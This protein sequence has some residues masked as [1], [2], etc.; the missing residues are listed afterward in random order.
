VTQVPGDKYH[1]FHWEAIHLISMVWRDDEIGGLGG[2]ME[3]DPVLVLYV[4]VHASRE[5]R[6]LFI[7]SEHFDVYATHWHPLLGLCTCPCSVK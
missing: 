5:T 6:K 4:R 7:E 3:R 2:L 1:N